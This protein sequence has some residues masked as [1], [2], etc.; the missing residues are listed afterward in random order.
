[1]RRFRRLH[2][3]AHMRP[4]SVVEADYALQNS[5][6]FIA[7][8]DSHLV[9]PFRLQDAVGSLRNG[10]FKRISA[11]G[12]ADAYTVLLELRYIRIATVLA[13]PVRVMDK[14]AGRLV[15]YRLQSHLQSL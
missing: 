14:A 10:V 6:A 3:Y 1:M 8:S 15:I 7:G 9:Q 2:P 12:H 11:L 13:A 5:P 4:L